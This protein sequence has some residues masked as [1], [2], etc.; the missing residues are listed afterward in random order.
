MRGPSSSH[1]AAAL[2]IGRLARDLMRSGGDPG[3]AAFP[4]GGLVHVEYDPNGSLVTTHRGQGSDMGL[5]GGLLGWAPDDPRLPDYLEHMRKERL[6]CEVA[7]TSYGARHPNTYKLHLE[8]SKGRVHNM[9]AISTGGGIIELEEVDGLPVHSFGDFHETLFFLTGMSRVSE[10]LSLAQADPCVLHAAVVQ[11]Q[12]DALHEPLTPRGALAAL[13]IKSRAAL[14]EGLIQAL[15]TDLS[16]ESVRCFEPVLP[17]L[18]S[19]T[20]HLPFSNASE[21]KQQMNACPDR[22]LWSWAL[23]YETARG[24]I[25]EREALDRMAHLVH[26]FRGAVDSGRRGTSYDDRILPTQAPSLATAMS[27]GRVLGGDLLN[28]VILYVTSIM[29]VKS[30]MGLIVAA[31]TAGSCGACPG[32]V[33]AVADSLGSTERQVCEAFLVAGLI[34]VFIQRDATFAAEVGG[35]MAEC[36]AG[37]SMAAAAI[38]SLAGGSNEQALAA[39]SLALQNAFGMTCDPIG[40]RV[41]APCLGKNVLAA[42]NALSCANMAL[43]DFT[44]VVPLDEV[45]LA[46]DS[47]GKQMPRELRCTGLGGLATTPTGLRI[48]EELEPDSAVNPPTHEEEEQE[49]TMQRG[50]TLATATQ[51]RPRG[52]GGHKT[53]C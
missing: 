46:M 17:I 41:E 35:C 20:F 13:Q 39:A 1:S 44:A 36:G 11:Q 8:D 48:L 34:G 31:P 53:P 50:K 38:V 25:S 9:A 26:V 22:P 10:A 37:S 28:S 51:R 18:S 14:P 7:Y 15:K 12:S 40:N 21:I 47:V 5:A 29:E 33:L 43:S 23:D 16:A 45:I 30:S 27:Q 49:D 52:V 42:S 4:R 19:P 6:V 32:A 24:G 2:R 3:D